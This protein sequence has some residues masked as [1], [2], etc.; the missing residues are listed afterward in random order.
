MAGRFAHLSAKGLLGLSFCLAGAAHA[1]PPKVC[2][3]D[4]MLGNFDPT[5]CPVLRDDGVAP[6]QA[7][8]DGVYSV[9]VTLSKKPLLE[10][11]LLPSG[12]FDGS[13][14]GQ[15]GTCDVQGT[16]TNTYANIQIPEPDTSRPVRFFYDSRA[17]ADPTHAAPPGNR[18]VGDDLML[19]S[20][21]AR[22]PQWLVVGDFQGVP[23]DRTIGTVE[24]KLQSPGVLV[25][26]LTAAKALA[27]GWRWRVVQGGAG[28]V[29][30]RQYGPSG[31]ADEPCEADNVQV[32]S[33][34]R[35]GDIVYFTWS[36]ATGRLR[37][38]VVA[39]GD[40]TADGGVPGGLPLC[41]PPVGDPPDLGDAADLAAPQVDGSGP[42]T[43]GDAQTGDAGSALPR[44]G[45]HCDC[46]LGQ[47]GQAGQ[48]GQTGG[49]AGAGPAA[50]G[51][52]LA[53]AYLVARSRRF[54]L[55]GPG[56]PK[57]PEMARR[58]GPPLAPKLNDILPG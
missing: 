28:L 38:V 31:W 12:T 57:L 11:K 13:Q 42:L 22:C 25:G 19:R 30:A 14:L 53:A 6:D 51:L 9:E 17:P 46:R 18:S 20:P 23:F 34:V 15:R 21:A 27:G 4:A 58:N 5:S 32:A 52:G 24:L 48:P 49:A 33:A 35:P 36:S 8:G 56:D 43:D 50:V 39:P 41:P 7:A 44:P 55:R 47:A 54:R 16:R 29:G 3:N 37:T 45:I 2:G 26:R 1:D 40:D 10:Y